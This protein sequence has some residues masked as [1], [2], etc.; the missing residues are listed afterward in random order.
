MDIFKQKMKEYWLVRLLA[1]SATNPNWNNFL[2]TLDNLFET[3]TTLRELKE[4]QRDLEKQSHQDASDHFNDCLE[5]FRETGPI[6][7][8][9]L[10]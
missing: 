6:R 7:F 1:V 10:R 3:A 4:F 8:E 9:S 2:Q 5:K